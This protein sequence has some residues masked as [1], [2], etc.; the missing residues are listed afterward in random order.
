MNLCA[1]RSSPKA[2]RS[3][4]IASSHE[5]DEIREH[6]GA[7]SLAYLSLP[8]LLSCVGGAPE[9]YCTACWSGEYRVAIGKE[10]YH[11]ELFPIRTEAVE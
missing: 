10:Q 4:L 6:I 7:E 3:Q 1:F 9:S 11:Q 2:R 8:G 5:V